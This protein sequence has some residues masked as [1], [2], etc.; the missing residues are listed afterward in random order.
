LLPPACST[1]LVEVA[2]VS[3]SLGLLA[4]VVVDTVGGLFKRLKSITM[5][6]KT[7]GYLD[8]CL[9][10][11]QIPNNFRPLDTKWLGTGVRKLPVQGPV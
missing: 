8:A 10:F 4:R 7:S 5:M 1:G 9:V 11:D 2:A 6:K 3:V